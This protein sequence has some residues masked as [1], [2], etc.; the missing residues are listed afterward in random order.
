[1]QW[2]TGSEPKLDVKTKLL[3]T[4]EVFTNVFSK[5]AAH[6]LLTTV[7]EGTGTISAS[8]IHSWP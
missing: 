5:V 8:V 1:M 6:E 3:E 2:H 4:K 7:V